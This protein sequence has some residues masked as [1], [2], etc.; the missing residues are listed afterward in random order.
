VAAPRAIVPDVLARLAAIV[1]CEISSDVRRSSVAALSCVTSRAEGAALLAAMPDTLTVLV[2]CISRTAC[3]LH[4]LCDVA[5]AAAGAD[6]LLSAG[7]V[8][9]VVA[10]LQTVTP[11]APQD[12]APQSPACP[13]LADRD[14][15]TDAFAVLRAVM[16]RDSG[17][18][19]SI[20]ARAPP[21][22]VS[23]V[24][25]LPEAPSRTIVFAL[26]AMSA[27]AES[28]AGVA[29]ILK[30]D[31]V[32]ELVVSR[33]MCAVPEV[34]EQAL[35]TA[36][37]LV[38]AP[39][40]RRLM[41]CAL[42]SHPTLLFRVFPPPAA[43]LSAELAELLSQG[44]DVDTSA[45][46]SLLLAL[47]DPANQMAGAEAA[48]VAA[49]ALTRASCMRRLRA[50]LSVPSTSAQLKLSAARLFELLK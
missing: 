38:V 31:S 10:F 18:D 50:I 43:A 26:G 24:R 41:C 37:H 12:I 6:A 30:E 36:K 2:K 16:E 22:L 47:V 11:G 27:L 23:Y 28:T 48:S 3:V 17:R 5:S 35:S 8:A 44:F 14:T 39:L 46:V 7:A 20:S 32:V 19:A 4:P 1:N 42:L 29:S 9:A 13:I 40:G 49:A 34:A 21:V 25:L 15:Q 33:L 45:L